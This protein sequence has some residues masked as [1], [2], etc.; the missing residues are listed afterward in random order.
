MEVVKI[1]GNNE[2]GDGYKYRGRG[3]MQLTGRAN[4]QAFED[5]YNAQNDDEIDI[6]SDPDQVASDPILAIESALWAFKSKVLDRMDVNNKT[7]V[8]AVTKKINGGKN[9]LSDRKSKFN[10][11]KQNVDC[12]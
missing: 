2:P 4:Y 10:S 9:G 8:D 6:M 12:D 5:F 1:N 3:A 11:V 7:S